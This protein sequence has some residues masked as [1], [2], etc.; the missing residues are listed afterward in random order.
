M[1][2]EE[3]ARRRKMLRDA[4]MHGK[5]AQARDITIDGLRTIMGI[6]ASADHRKEAAKVGDVEYQADDA[7]E[8]GIVGAASTTG[9]KI[10]AKSD[11]T[12]KGEEKFTPLVGENG[13]EAITPRKTR[14]SKGD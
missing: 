6:D 12:E 14:A 2:C 7:G 13:P 9:G 11:C 10:S 8:I 1:A 3:C 4:V 5:M